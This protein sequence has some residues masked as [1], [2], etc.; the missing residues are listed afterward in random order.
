VMDWVSS[1][2]ACSFIGLRMGLLAEGLAWYAVL[3]QEQSGGTELWSNCRF[4]L[5]PTR[6][7]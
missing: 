3:L 4:S 2:S 6:N 1:L 7:I 5:Q